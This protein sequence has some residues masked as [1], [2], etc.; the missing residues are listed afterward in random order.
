[1]NIAIIGSNGFIGRHLTEQ[2]IDARAHNILLFGRSSSSHFGRTLPY[3]ILDQNNQ[4]EVIRQFKDVDLVYYLASNSIPASSW[5]KPQFE[6]EHNLSPFINFMEALSSTA[7]K[8]I[9]FVSSAGTIYGP[10]DKKLGEDAPKHPFSPYGIT[11][12]SMEYF[13][14]YFQAKYQIQHDICRVSNVYG[15]GQDTSSGLGLINTFLE[16]IIQG[17]TL[18]VFGTGENKRNYIFVKDVAQL[19]AYSA[20]AT[21]QESG[22]Y[23]IASN[24]SI[25][26]NDVLTNIKTVIQQDVIVDFSPSR[27]SDNSA[28]LLDN[29]RILSRFPNFQ[30]TEL[31][32]GIA[33]T[34]EYIKT[35][36]HSLK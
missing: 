22:I 9:C 4:Q 18:Q 28:I 15:M 30:F 2:L 5:H 24:D 17:K 3:Q 8:K 11:K 26:I 20:S 25:S 23:N 1:M 29:A 34:Y 16:K 6:I 7:V 19:L 31:Q 12:L 21:Q 13:L 36:S 35:H 10:S 32:D 33:Q 27:E 14:N